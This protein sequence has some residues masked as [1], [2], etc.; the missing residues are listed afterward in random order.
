MERAVVFS[1]DHVVGVRFQ[2]RIVVSYPWRFW[3]PTRVEN[4][5]RFWSSRERTPVELFKV[6]SKL[7]TVAR[8]INDTHGFSKLLPSR[9]ERPGNLRGRDLE[10]VA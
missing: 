10:R 8:K 2:G 5:V 6:T 7:N 4:G 1:D 9:V 3:E